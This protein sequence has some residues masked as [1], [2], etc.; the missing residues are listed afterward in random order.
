MISFKQ[1]EPFLKN[2]TLNLVIKQVEDKLIVSILPKPNIE[3]K[4]KENLIPLVIK[5]TVEELD[6]EFISLVNTQLTE[7][8]GII[9]NIAAFEAQAKEMKDK[10]EAQ[11]KAKDIKKKANEAS[12]KELEGADKLLEEKKYDEC[13]AKI[14][15]ALKDNAEYKPALSL[16]KKLDKA[17]PNQV[18]IF[19]VIEEEKAPATIQE[20]QKIE[21]KP[22]PKIE[23]AIQKVVETNEPVV[24]D[25]A[26]VLVSTSE[27]PALATPEVPKVVEDTPTILEIKE[28]PQQSKP[29]E[30]NNSF[31]ADTS[32]SLAP[33]PQQTPIQEPNPEEELWAGKGYDRGINGSNEPIIF[34]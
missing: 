8:T 30:P 16:Q 11:K 24:I 28:E 17:K 2:A 9:N 18:D 34:E 19:G 10:S 26:N 3:D 20:A 27:G 1:L 5:G 15:K 25:E 22:E 23:K 32:V 4:S 6:Q 14:D 7:A 13:Q 29:I 31:D 33:Q 21:T 12:K